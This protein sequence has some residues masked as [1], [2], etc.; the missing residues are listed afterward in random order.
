MAVLALVSVFSSQSVNFLSSQDLQG[1]P[2]AI[3]MYV[4]FCSV[5]QVKNTK[6]KI[7]RIWQDLAGSSRIMQNSENSVFCIYPARSCYPVI[8]LF[9]MIEHFPNKKTILCAVGTRLLL[10]HNVAP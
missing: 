2:S 10:A 8:F 4:F 7:N 9:L 3:R 1:V 5:Y 6:T